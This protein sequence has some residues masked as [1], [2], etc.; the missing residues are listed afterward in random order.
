MKDRIDEPIAAILTLNTIS[1]TAGA[2]ISGAIALQLF[3]SEWMALF[4]AILTLLILVFSEIIPK[5]IG[6]NYWKNLSPASA[7]ILKAMIILLKPL[8]VPINFLSQ[9]ISRG[10][11]SDAITRAEIKNF[12]RL[13]HH[14]GS[15]EQNE[16]RIVDNLFSLKSV[17]VGEIMTPRKVVFTLED[18]WTVGDIR[19]N[20][21]ELY[22]SRIP[23]I[24]EKEGSITG[25]VMHR[26][27]MS[28][29][30]EEE[31]SLE[32]KSIAREPSFVHEDTPVYNVLN[33]MIAQKIHLCIVNDASEKYRGIITLEDALE[34]LLGREIVDEFDPAVDMR[35]LAD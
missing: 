27:I 14:Q 15:I 32:L 4:S 11:T 16:Y 5:T 18:S 8:I 35:D 17:T 23:L 22:F 1:H 34:T 26:D 28:H 9:A 12:I 3:G 33:Y 10:D 25:I 20:K 30:T 6:A 21:I 19:N 24:N 13:G 29:M 2:A 31:N 7:W